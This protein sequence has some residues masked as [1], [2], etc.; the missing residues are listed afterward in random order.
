MLRNPEHL[1]DSHPLPRAL[2][3]NHPLAFEVCDAIKAAATIGIGIMRRKALKIS[4][5]PVSAPLHQCFGG[6]PNG[7]LSG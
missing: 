1:V 7:I 3:E 6:L 4:I 2:L 5:L